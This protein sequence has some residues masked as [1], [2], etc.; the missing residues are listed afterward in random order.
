[1]A[2]HNRN[3]QVGERVAY[4]AAFL[5]ST[6]QVVG[7]AGARRGVIIGFDVLSRDTT[8]ARIEW[9]GE[10]PRQDDGEPWRV[11]VLNLARVGSAAMSAN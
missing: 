8:L 11:N 7:P 3:L 5:R 10:P 6:G 9:E 1:M 4:S 2:K